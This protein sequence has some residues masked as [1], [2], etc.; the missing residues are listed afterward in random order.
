MNRHRRKFIGFLTIPLPRAGNFIVYPVNKVRRSTQ[1]SVGL[2]KWREQM[3]E[4]RTWCR[5]V[6]LVHIEGENLAKVI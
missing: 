2:L 3:D 6:T 4:F 5:G 1:V